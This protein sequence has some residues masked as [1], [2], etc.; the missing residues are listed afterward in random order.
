VPF[1]SLWPANTK[2]KEGKDNVD[3]AKKAATTWRISILVG[4][5]TTFV[6]Q[7]DSI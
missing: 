3:K 6:R 4:V 5:Y 7:P 2:S 1:V